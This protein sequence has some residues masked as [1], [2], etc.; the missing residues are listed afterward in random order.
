VNRDFA[1]T[2]RAAGFAVLPL[3]IMVA[4]VKLL[5]PDVPSEI[6]IVGVIQ[7][8]LI[9][10]I[11][12]GFVIVYRAN[13]I[14]NF[15]AADLGGVPASFAL[16][17]FATWG[18]NIYLA[19]TIGLASAILLGVIVE[20]VFLRRFFEAPRLILTVATIGI[21]QLLAALAYLLPFWF[22]S[23]EITKYEPFI[24]ANFTRGLITFTGSDLMVLIVVPLVLLALGLFFRFSPVG[25]ALR[26]TAENADRAMLLGIPVRRLQSVVWGLAALLAFIAMWLRIGIGGQVLGIALDPSV[27]LTALGAAV[28]GRMERMPTTVLAAIGLGIVGQAAVFHFDQFQSMSIAIRALIIAVALLWQRGDVTSRLASSATSTWTATREVRRLPAE[29]KRVPA[30]RWAYAALGALLVAGLVAIPMFLPEDKVRVSTTIAIFAIVCLSLVTLTG[31]AGQVSLGQMGFVGLAGA[32]AGTFAT[33]YDWDIILVLLAGGTVGAISTMIVG[34]PSLRARGLAFAIATLAFSLATSEYLLTDSRSP[35]KSWVPR[36]VDRTAVF[37]VI[38]VDTET[39]FYVLVVLVLAGCI[40]MMRSL[41]NSRVGR[42]MIGVRDNERAAQAYSIGAL[43]AL[44][45]AFATSGFL[46]GVAGALL[47]LQQ[48]ALDAGNFHP[49]QGLAAFSM[50]VVGGLGSI[51]GA[52]LGA[53]YVK[54]IQ[55]FLTERQWAFLSTG[56]GLL[57]VLLLL[58]GGLGAAVGD[59]RDSILRWYAKRRGIRVPSLVADTRV[60]DVEVPEANLVDALAASEQSPVM[61]EL[62]EMHD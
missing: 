61:E 2:A 21:T 34:I 45:V 39:R 43:G 16:L 19:T 48:G 32:F 24:D 55:Y 41:R 18:W 4:G 62:A 35:I 53:I 37:G 3:A 56:V 12:L 14:V 28:I 49:G 1:D 29:L 13:R 38:K 54:G 22:G 26:A 51:G 11:G 42:V 10:L 30:V 46:A 40:M 44:M 5:W 27:L 8:L 33:K 36:S 31:W 7:G 59:A 47:V 52:V 23:T 57:L 6:Y 15:A 58:P 60:E 9:G 25:M 17:L 50:V 20:F